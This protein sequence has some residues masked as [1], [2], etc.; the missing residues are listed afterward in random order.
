MAG[1]DHREQR[2]GVLFGLEAVQPFLDDQEIARLALP[3]L[4][5]F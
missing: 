5:G 2:G 3:G 4:S 1:L